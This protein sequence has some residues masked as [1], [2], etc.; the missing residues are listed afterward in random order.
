MG[1]MD[2]SN[3]ISICGSPVIGWYRQNRRLPAQGRGDASS[4]SRGT[5]RRFIFPRGDEVPPRLPAG[6]R[7]DASTPRTGTR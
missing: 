6:E 7:G 1:G 3:R 5:R 4:S 2:K